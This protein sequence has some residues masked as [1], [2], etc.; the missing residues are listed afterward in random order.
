MQPP[1]KPIWH[2]PTAIMSEK[3]LTDAMR[4]GFDLHT[5]NTERGNRLFRLSRAAFLLRL[6]R[7][8]SVPPI[9]P[10]FAVRSSK[11]TKLRLGSSPMVVVS[12]GASSR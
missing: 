3:D 8:N 5:T 9:E 12:R 11:V 4:G 10:S 6:E 2:W 1:P 7:S